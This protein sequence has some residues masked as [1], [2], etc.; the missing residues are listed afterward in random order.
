MFSLR[1]SFTLLACCQGNNVWVCNRVN[2]RPEASSYDVLMLLCHPYSPLQILK[3]LGMYEIAHCRENNGPSNT[4]PWDNLFFDHSFHTLF[5][6]FNFSIWLYPRD[7]RRICCCILVL[8]VAFS[9]PFE[10][11]VMHFSGHTW[12]YRLTISEEFN[13]KKIT[14]LFWQLL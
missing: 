7:L 13:Y 2:C 11:L 8:T 14:S 6:S 4:S 3:I 10:K 9:G 1:S 12:F 5:L